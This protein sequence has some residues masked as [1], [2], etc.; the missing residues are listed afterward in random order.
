MNYGLVGTSSTRSVSTRLPRRRDPD[1]RVGHAAETT[2]GGPSDFVMTTNRSDGA[3]SQT[4]SSLKW[5]VIA[6]H[7]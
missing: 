1:L 3:S 5:L 6:P 2:L 4:A 7:R